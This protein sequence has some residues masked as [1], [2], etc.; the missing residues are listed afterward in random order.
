MQ[1]QERHAPSRQRREK[2]EEITKQPQPRVLLIQAM[3][4]RVVDVQRSDGRTWAQ[5]REVFGLPFVMSAASSWTYATLHDMLMLHAR[6]F[7]RS[8]RRDRRID[9]AVPDDRQAAQMPFVA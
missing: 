5:R 7:L 3:H 2:A 6:R 8:N 1:Y 9:G 4:R